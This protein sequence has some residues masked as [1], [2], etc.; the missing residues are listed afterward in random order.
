MGL[1]TSYVFLIHVKIITQF[2]K[3]CF[4]VSP[5][6]ILHTT[7]VLMN[8]VRKVSRGERQKKE[9]EDSLN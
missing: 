2:F 9:K 3:M 5:E 7:A 8:H 1:M 4:H 6:I